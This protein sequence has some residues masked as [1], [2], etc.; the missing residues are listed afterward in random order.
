MP[1]WTKEQQQAI[2]TDGT[3]ILVSAGA[4]SGKTAV[5]TNR[6]INKLKNNVHINE[7][8]ILT[9]TKE[10]AKEMKERIRKSLNEDDNLKQELE[11]LD[12]SYITTFDAFA[13]SIVKKYHYI[14]NVSH[15]IGV[16]DNT[17]LSMKKKEIMDLVFDSYYQDPPLNFT[18]L[19]YDFC[20]KDDKEL[21][22]SLLQIANKLELFIDKDAYLA[23]YLTNYYDDKYIDKL[24]VDYNSLLIEKKNDIFEELDNFYYIAPPDYFLKVSASLENLKSITDIDSLININITLPPVPRNSELELKEAKEKLKK[25]IDELQKYQKYGTISKIKES[26]LLT[27]DT[28]EIIIAILKK[29]FEQ[30]DS[31]KVNNSIYD[32]QDIALLAIKLVK[33]NP[34]IRKEISNSFKEIMIDEYQDTNDI[35]EELISLIS[36][37]NIYMV[38]DVKQ[39]I[40][41]FRNANPYIFKDKYDKY[42]KNNNGI[43]IDLLQNFRSREEVLNNINNIFKYIMDDCVGGADYLNTHQMIYGNKTYQEEGKTK[44]NY[45][46]EFLEYDIDNEYTKDEIEIFAIGRDIQNKVL[47]KYQVFDKDKRKLHDATYNDFVILMDRSTKFDLY[48]KIFEYLGIPL[49]IYK[50]ERI[51]EGNDLFVIKSLIDLLICIHD[52][53]IDTKFKYSFISIA[54]SY[55]Y[56][57]DDDKIFTF[58]LNN[59]FKDSII[60]Q[61]LKDIA[62]TINT[63]TI[64][65]IL[66]EL[67][68]KTNLYEKLTTTQEIEGSMIKIT[69]LMA[70]AKNLSDIG[71]DIYDF[72]NYLDTLIEEEYE[73]NY[74]L[75]ISNN[76][77]VKIM[78]I[79]KSKGLEY[80]VCYFSGLD[81]TFNI[82]D[83]KDK[84]IFS[85]NYGIITPLFK[86]GICETIIKELYTDDFYL[87]EV[88]EKIRLFYVALTRAKEKMIFVIPNKDGINFKKNEEGII[89]KNIRKKYRSFLDIILSIKKILNNYIKKI[90]IKSLY[91]TKNY[92]LNKENLFNASS[93]EKLNVEELDIKEK[94]V[95]LTS[96]S[97]KLN[98]LITAKEYSNL[99]FGLLIHETLE[100]LDFK[101]PN[102]DVIKDDF[103]RIKVKRFLENPLLKDIQNAKIYKE[104]EFV[105]QKDSNINHGIVDLILEYDNYI[106]IIDYKLS[107]V[108]DDNYLK[109][110]NGY[111]EYIHTLSTKKVNIYLYSIIDEKIKEIS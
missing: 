95:N 42:S 38:G 103:I 19:I 71:Y 79:H 98:S 9:F 17:I 8:L 80:N 58:F 30:L 93:L 83:I 89:S 3:N 10:A 37:N 56:N 61:D 28:T 40:Y 26:I 59:N 69:K 72:N 54:R 4:G 92:L 5:L 51:D 64:Y 70:S 35:Q 67:I 91:I 97:K 6:V 32:F 77:A 68:N 36:N 111:R 7:L 13:L 46:M 12:S 94:E 106:D 66:N 31:Y 53:K 39:S 86:E 105:Y 20:G 85:N 23:D 24:I 27:K 48:K 107:N 21:R 14:L 52:N 81:K 60:Y 41:R 104:Y 75:D 63:K 49:A 1:K 99:S 90:D 76:N 57:I 50:D 2:F 43:K 16:T 65:I 110:L 82:S 74:S 62:K 108:E 102:L 73:M 15:E 33:D 55:L 45:D 87:E 84:F 109:Q 18:K 47:N 34:E 78:T 101:N 44:Q 88:S 96:Y 29:Y 11:Y 100:L 22:K 25:K